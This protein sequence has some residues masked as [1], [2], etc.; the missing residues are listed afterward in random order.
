MQYGDCFH[1]AFAGS[2]PAQEFKLAGESNSW[3]Q[4]ANLNPLGE[5]CSK[6]LVPNSVERN[7]CK[8]PS[9][10]NTR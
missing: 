5:S 3:V 7:G 10:F 8:C 2:I 1:T 6:Y 4:V 9:L